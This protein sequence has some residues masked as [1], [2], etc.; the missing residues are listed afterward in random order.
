MN[1]QRPKVACKHPGCPELVRPPKRFC[2]E[3]ETTSPL[4]PKPWAKNEGVSAHARGYGARWRKLRAAFLR[5]RPLCQDCEGRGVITEATTVDHVV[6]KHLGGRD[7]WRNLQA[8]CEP[9]HNRKT[10]REGARARRP[11]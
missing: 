8:L 5:A 3:H 9:C 4:R 10:G 6:P 2:A 7:E 1:P 11:K